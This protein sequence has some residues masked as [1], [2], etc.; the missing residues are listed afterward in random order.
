MK[1]RVIDVYPNQTDRY[2]NF[3]GRPISRKILQAAA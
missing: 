3:T 1:F 2:D